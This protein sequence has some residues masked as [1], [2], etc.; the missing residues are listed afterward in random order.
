[1]PWRPRLPT[2]TR[3]T[4]AET[5]ACT[6][7]ASS[8]ISETPGA[9]L[10]RLAWR[11]STST[12]FPPVAQTASSEALDR[13]ANLRRRAHGCRGLLGAVV[14]DD[15]RARELAVPLGRG[16]R[17]EHSAGRVVQQLRHGAS[18]DEPGEAAVAVAADDRDRR[19]LVGE[20]L[21][22][23]REHRSFEHPRLDGQLRPLLPDL[24]RGLAERLVL[25][26]DRGRGGRPRPRVPWPPPRTPRPP[27][28]RGAAASRGRR[29]PP[30]AAP[31]RP[32]P[33]SRRP[34]TRSSRTRSRPSSPGV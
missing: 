33:A 18:E 5:R 10:V 1:M 15:D 11:V 2:T 34:R 16:A 30:P 20:R 3:S 32:R 19:L 25:E 17:D 31:P 7:S 6:G 12:S 29:A 24:P 13:C 27:P 28:R 4:P 8:T 22:Q 9:T 23:R 14:A 26:L 21:E